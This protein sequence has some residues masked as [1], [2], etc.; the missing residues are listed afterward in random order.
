MSELISVIVPV[1]NIEDYLPRCLACLEM[2]TYKN[3]EIIL[4]DDGSTDGSGKICDEY[5][6]K[7]P[8]A[9][10]IHQS[11][12]GLWAARNAG[13]DA[14]NG[15]YLW[16]PDGD[17]YFH[18]D[19]IKIM[20]EAINH[21]DRNGNKFNLAVVDYVESWTFDEDVSSHSKICL[22]E[23]SGEELFCFPVTRNP[24]S[25]ENDRKKYRYISFMWNKLY[26]RELIEDIRTG[27]YKYAQDHDF[28]IKVLLNGAKA[29]L[30]EQVL[31]YWM[32]RETSNMRQ[33]D[34]QLIRAQCEARIHYNHLVNLP[35]SL[36]LYE[37]YLLEW[38]YRWMAVWE[39]ITQ[40]TKHEREVQ[41]ECITM[42]KRTWKSYL[43]CKEIGCFRK[44][45]KKLVRVGLPGFSKV[46][47]ACTNKLVGLK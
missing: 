8:R 2:Q 30:V 34:Y 35:K 45:L 6:A 26:R 40:G 15:E 3:L 36:L 7:D 25:S 33:S 17:D 9:R 18:K 29:V 12:K 41:S 43:L 28:N 39:S 19:I 32:Q 44:R 10:V 11:N 42:V 46:Y 27:N 38:L 31:Y 37:R 4:V 22:K 16:F 20:Y 13:Q 23:L 24:K 5:A 1:Y 47:Y 21:E 14:A